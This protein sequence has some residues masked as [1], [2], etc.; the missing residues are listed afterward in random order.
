MYEYIRQYI[1]Y[2]NYSISDIYF[3]VVLVHPAGYLDGCLL[4]LQAGHPLLQ[5]CLLQPKLLGAFSDLN[6]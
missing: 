2:K 3:L 5:V 1:I 4:V 6:E